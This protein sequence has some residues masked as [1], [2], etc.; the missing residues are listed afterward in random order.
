MRKV[1]HIPPLL[2]LGWHHTT[3]EGLLWSVLCSSL[4]T[5]PW[6]YM[7]SIPSPCM[8]MCC[9]PHSCQPP[10]SLVPKVEWPRS[11]LE[12]SKSELVRL[13]VCPSLGQRVPGQIRPVVGRH[14]VIAVVGVHSHSSAHPHH[15]VHLDLGYLHYSSMCQP[16]VQA[17]YMS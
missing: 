2:G 15:I 12:G 5:Y 7:T 13:W 8:G 10:Q 9:S 6:S 14:I 4:Q 17:S 1:A 3:N 16:H 11:A